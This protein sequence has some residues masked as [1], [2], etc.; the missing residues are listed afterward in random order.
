MN[1]TRVK[2]DEKKSEEEVRRCVDLPVVPA[3][4]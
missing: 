4:S 3:G 1:E 2:W